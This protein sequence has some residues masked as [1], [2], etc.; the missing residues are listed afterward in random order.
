MVAYD[1]YAY[2]VIYNTRQDSSEAVAA[3]ENGIYRIHLSD[4]SY[5]VIERNANSDTE[6]HVTSDDCVY[7]IQGKMNI[8]YQSKRHIYK[9]DYMSGQKEKLTV[10]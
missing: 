1:Q 6:I 5:E 2:A 10:I 4:G 7:I 9:F 3:K 8:L